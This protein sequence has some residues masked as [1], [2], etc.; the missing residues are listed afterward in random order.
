MT[1]LH[2][3][4]RLKRIWWKI[5]GINQIGNNVPLSTIF[6]HPTGIVIGG[7]VKM[8][9]NCR[10]SQGVTIGRKSFE[11]HG[12]PEIGNNVKIYTNSVIIGKIKIG[13]NATIG[14]LSFVDKNIP[15]NCVVVGNPSRIIKISESE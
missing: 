3:N 11:R 9:E 15:N 2:I 6:P 12:Q 13:N 10:I 7:H 8:G 4:K 5:S 14:A 1:R